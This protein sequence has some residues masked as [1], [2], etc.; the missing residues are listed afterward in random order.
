MVA[1]L[2][3]AGVEHL[4][5]VDLHLQTGTGE[6][7]VR[8]EPGD[9]RLRR[10]AHRYRDRVDPAADAKPGDRPPSAARHWRRWSTSRPRTRRGS[11]GVDQLSDPSA[12]SR[13]VVSRTLYRRFGRYAWWL[14]VPFVVACL[15][16]VAVTPW[17]L[18]HLGSACR[19][20]PSATPTPPTST[21]SS[22]WPWSSPWSCSPSWPWCSA[23]SAAACGRSSAAGPSTRC[24]PRR[25]PTTRPATTPGGWSARGYAGLIT[26]ATF[27][28]ELTNLGTGFYANVGRHRR[29][30]GRA[31]RPARAAPRLPAQPVGQLGRDR[32]RAPSSTSACSWPATSCA[33]R[34][35]SSGWSPGA[36]S[37]APSTRR[38][39]PPIRSAIR[40]RRPPT[41][42]RPTAA[43]D[44]CGG[45]RR[46]P[47]SS[48]GSSTSSTPS[49]RR[50]AAACTWSSSSCPSGPAWPPVPWWP[51]PGWPWWRS[52]GASC[53]ASAG[54]GGC[55]WSCWPAPSSSTWWP[56]P[57]SRSRSSPRAVLAFLLVNRKEFQA[58]SEPPRCGRP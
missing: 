29:G 28:S 53:A 5:P 19:P 44:G 20:G 35:A 32:V 55:R 40:G 14:L 27:R 17:V 41:S 46:P 11:A 54:P 37:A 1:S 26:A 45:G 31:P 50:C 33:R 16:R 10:R 30:G 56:A 25:P 34:A 8:V 12:L 51:W 47:S 15:L 22:W 38:W 39:W 58:A 3:A 49:P 43:P 42:A 13:F 2:A 24:A 18:G 9:A 52:A 23:C 48:P 57:T 7:V 6:R 36:G 4:G 21:T